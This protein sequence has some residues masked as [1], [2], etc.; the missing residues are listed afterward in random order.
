M[1]GRRDGRLRSSRIDHDD[2]WVPPIATDA[3][4][5][6]RMGDA[7][8]RPD[9]HENIGLFKIRVGIGRRVEA[10]GLFVSFDGRGHTLTRVS[11]AVSDAESKLAEAAEEG[12][13]LCGHLPRPQPGDGVR[14][15]SFLD[16]AQSF[17][18]R[19]HR[20]VPG[21]RDELPILIA[22]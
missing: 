18:E 10:K 12:E 22:A 2:L 16:F 14:A 9:Q 21:N 20:L 6:D 15:M 13:L 4:P 17:D 11:I 7:E 8:I 3:L 5:E 19:A 1:L